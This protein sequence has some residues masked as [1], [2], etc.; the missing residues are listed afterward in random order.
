M[1]YNEALHTVV[2]T[3]LNR[4]LGKAIGLLENYLYTYQQLQ[5]M[6]L[7]QELKADYELMVSYWEKGYQDVQRGQLYDQLLRRMYV[8]ATNIYILYYRHS[9]SY[10]HNLMNTARS[11][12]E[13]WTPDLIRAEMEGF[14]TDV[15]LL[16]L[17]PEHVRRQRQ[18]KQERQQETS[19]F[20]LIIALPVRPSMQICRS[21]SKC[22]WRRNSVS[23]DAGIASSRAVSKHSPSRA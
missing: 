6:E 14:V 1:V 21:S 16:E 22:T 10:V 18:Q 4:Q 17:E 12:R 8:L 7:L 11:T 5:Y 23:N 2:K 3:V 13:H 15:A 20:S 19:H 9:S